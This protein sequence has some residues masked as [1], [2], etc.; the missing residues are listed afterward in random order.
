M[1][2]RRLFLSRLS[3]ACAS[4]A[5]AGNVLFK[6]LV[7]VPREDAIRKVVQEFMLSVYYKGIVETYTFNGV[8]KSVFK[9][10]NN[11][12]QETNEFQLYPPPKNLKFEHYY[13][14][15]LSQY[16][17]PQDGY[18]VSESWIAEAT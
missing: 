5:L 12:T 1:T 14:Y 16:W 6:E 13:G 8:R 11:K 18:Q 15:G 9:I 4:A 3:L 7:P 17:P 2:T 10:V